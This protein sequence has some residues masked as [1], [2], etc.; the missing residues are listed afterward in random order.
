[1]IK[2]LQFVLALLVA[3]VL[4]TASVRAGGDKDKSPEDVFKSYA[5]AVK[6]DD[7][8]AMMSH[9]TR[10]SQAGA[11]GSLYLVG[12][13]DRGFYGFMNDKIS[14]KQKKEYRA[15]IDAVFNRYGLSDDALM[16]VFEKN[17]KKDSMTDEKQFMAIGEL[18]KDKA[19][20]VTEIL[21][22]SEDGQKYSGAFNEIGA[23]KMKEVKIDG[24]QAKGLVTFPGAD[25]KEKTA[26]VY[27][28]LENGDWKIDLYETNR[29]WP[30]PPPQVQR[31]ATQVQPSATYYNS[32]PGL[33]RRLC[34][35]LR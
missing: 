11:A 17:Q 33:L 27:F 16:R 26:T 31:P 22:V 23:A 8:K 7:V 12:M 10:D 6:K 29:N 21:K 2:S 35:C 34:P 32:R 28:K 13:L 19:G 9:L 24:Q 20:F 15:A 3:S 25:G 30:P 5:T 18:V 1:M 14:D 4:L